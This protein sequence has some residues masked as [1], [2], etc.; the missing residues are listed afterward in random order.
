MAARFKDRLLSATRTNRSIVCVGL[1]FEMEYVPKS[2]QESEFPIFE[3][4]R[5]IIEATKDLV[6]AYKPN[7]A[8]YERHGERGWSMLRKTIELVPEEVPVILDVKRA[9][10]GNTSQKYAEA[11]FDDLGADAV[12]VNPYM[13]SDAVEPFIDYEDRGVF[14]L[15]RTTNPGAKDFQD[16]LV[17]RVP[18]F[19]HVARKSVEWNKVHDNVGIVGPATEPT[20]LQRLR[21]IVGPNMP[22]LAP[23]VGAQGGNIAVA[24]HHGA[25]LR[26]EMLLLNA[27]RS[28]LFAS[29][30]D[31]FAEAARRATARMRDQANDARNVSVSP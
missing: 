13:G 3:F 28:I 16:L 21:K 27:S 19:E 22:I 20:L 26:G 18:L 11:Y 23:G 5:A 24:V 30:E 15:C 12:T 29:Q 9:D 4:N 17:D 1:D 31:D 14:V 7:T 10:I 2:I 25:N 6:C 8:F